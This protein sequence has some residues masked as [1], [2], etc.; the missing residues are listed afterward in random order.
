M[1]KY[2]TVEKQYLVKRNGSFETR[3]MSDE[4]SQHETLES[5]LE[6]LRKE[7]MSILSF[8]Q[9]NAQ[10]DGKQTVLTVALVEISETD[11]WNFDY[12]PQDYYVVIQ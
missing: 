9:L 12:I 6:T 1:K 7:S 8:E 11:D 2:F 4:V 5:A 10:F 3:A